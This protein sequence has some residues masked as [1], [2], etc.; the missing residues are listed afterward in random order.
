MNIFIQISIVQMILCRKRSF[1]IFIFQGNPI[2]CPHGPNTVPAEVN[3]K[4]PIV[5]AG[6]GLGLSH[7]SRIW[8]QYLFLRAS[9]GVDGESQSAWLQTLP[10]ASS[11]GK[12]HFCQSPALRVNVH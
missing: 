11:K 12:K 4:T 7:L 3:E 6:V 5:L 10:R 2:Y 1:Y 9:T 8:V